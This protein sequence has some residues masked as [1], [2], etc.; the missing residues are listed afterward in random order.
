MS[1]VLSDSI[2]DRAVHSALLRREQVGRTGGLLMAAGTAL[3]VCLALLVCAFLDLLPWQVAIE[4]TAGVLTLVVLFYLIVRTGLNLRFKDPSLATEQTAAAIL[5][6]AYIMYH[7]WPAR[8]A[9]TL[10]Y[11]LAMLFGALRLSAARLAA[12]SVLA[13]VAHG[14]MLHF[15]YLRDQEYMDVEAAITEFAVLMIAL[16]WF[17]AMGGYVNRLRASLAESNRKLQQ[18]LERIHDIA[19]RDELT[20]AYNRRFLMETLAREHARASRLGGSFS[21]CLI[22]VDHFKKV[23]DT[24][25]HA[26]GDRLLKHV[27]AVAAQ[28]LRGVDVFGR[29]GGEEFLVVLPDTGRA[30]ALFVAERIRAA[31]ESAA[32]PVRVTVTIGIAEHAGDDVAAVL[33]RAD[34]A[35]YRGKAGGRNRVIG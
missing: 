23:N 15:S 35:L 19:I 20:G 5:F 1:E 28:G 7:A 2:T 33:A 3:L 29:F 12:L 13:L 14:T 17:A 16:P 25:G 10:F 8:E 22:D 21:V 34:Q 6:L 11:L 31:V 18:A 9:L 4:G 32:L 30:G 26:A 27:A 24:F